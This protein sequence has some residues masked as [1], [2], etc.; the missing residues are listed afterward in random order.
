MGRR[1]NVQPCESVM[2][3]LVFTGSSLA[4]FCISRSPG[5]HFFS[6]KLSP[7]STFPVHL[8]WCRQAAP[9]RGVNGS[10]C[11][12]FVLMNPLTSSPNDHRE[13]SQILTVPLEMQLF[14]SGSSC[15]KWPLGIKTTSEILISFS[16]LFQKLHLEWIDVMINSTPRFGGLSV[17][18]SALIPRGA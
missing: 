12:L 7:H 10:K 8:Q 6:L 9:F 15:N 2:F 13:R 4:S 3:L 11:D 5:L 17:P 14:S 1:F 18:L 16:D